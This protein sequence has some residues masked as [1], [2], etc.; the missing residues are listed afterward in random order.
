VARSLV[1]EL[2]SEGAACLIE[3]EQSC[4][5]LRGAKQHQAVTHSEAYEG[6]LQQPEYRS[7][8]RRRLGRTRVRRR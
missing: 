7:E 2:D 6:V 3:A 5:R 4:F 1:E 8:L